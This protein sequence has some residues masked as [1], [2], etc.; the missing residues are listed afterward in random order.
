MSVSYKIAAYLEEAGDDVDACLSTLGKVGIGT[1][2]LRNLYGGNICDTASDDTLKNIKKR[3][4]NLNIYAVSCKY[5]PKSDLVKYFN[6]S[7]FFGSSHIIIDCDDKDFLLSNIDKISELSYD[8]NKGVLIETKSFLSTFDLIG[9]T[10][11]HKKINILYDP[12]QII[13]NRRVDHFEK[14]WVLLKSR[15]SA[16]D[17][18]DCKIGRGFLPIGLGDV[19]VGKLLKDCDKDK[20]LIMEPN[21]GRR[22]RDLKSRS[23]TFLL[24]YDNLISIIHGELPN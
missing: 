24:S 22:F 18:R 23:E 19:A 9:I 11:D 3:T 1:I 6:I 2:I 21:L 20:L 16:V 15:I 17:V 13:L 7:E 4:N 8:Y 14:Y 10:R 12:V 5:N